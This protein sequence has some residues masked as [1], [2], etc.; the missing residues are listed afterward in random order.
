[1]TGAATCVPVSWLR[2][3]RY[4]LGELEPAER[5]T[6]AEHLSACG[7]CRARAD[8]ITEDS[9]R[10]LPPLPA[11][12][13]RAPAPARKRYAAWLALALAGAAAFVLVIRTPGEERPP[14]GRRVAVKG[15][16]VTIELVRERG[17]SIAWEPTSFSAADRFKL[18]LTC[19]PPL[20]VYA[21]L[22]VLQND[23]PA[24]P[25]AASLVT[26]GNRI[27]LAP[28]FRITGLG[29]ATVCVAADSD[30]PPSRA[31][32]SGSEPSAPGSRVC[33]HLVPRP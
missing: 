22:V 9:T 13:A 25:A 1:V 4:A 23:G 29:D 2:L 30:A 27:P 24:F 12:P 15:G 17:G 6:I 5:I 11:A 10:E 26:C 7:R 19:A 20:R 16:E 32:L 18:L 28:A 3:E 14:G 33:V 31:R 21:D 8:L